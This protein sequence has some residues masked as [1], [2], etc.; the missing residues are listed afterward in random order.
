MEGNWTQRDS[1][2]TLIQRVYNWGGVWTADGIY[3]LVTS[4]Q[5]AYS[6]IV[7]GSGSVSFDDN[8]DSVNF[9]LDPNLDGEDNMIPDNGL[10]TTAT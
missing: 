6:S 1:G 10:P 2:P 8:A 5:G 3:F 9:Y 7:H 4:T